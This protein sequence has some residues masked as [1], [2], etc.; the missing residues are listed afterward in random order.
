LFYKYLKRKNM[1]KPLLFSGGRG[2]R[3]DYSF[4]KEVGQLNSLSELHLEVVCIY[5]MNRLS[6][7]L[8]NFFEQ[9]IRCQLAFFVIACSRTI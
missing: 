9:S 7:L 5:W 1:Y 4:I 6:H 3:N 8:N 2:E